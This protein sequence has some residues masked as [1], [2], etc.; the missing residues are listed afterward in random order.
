MG[1]GTLKVLKSDFAYLE[2]IVKFLTC[3]ILNVNFFISNYTKYI[4]NLD[5]NLNPLTCNE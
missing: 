4:I 2:R 1:T 3:E 5:R